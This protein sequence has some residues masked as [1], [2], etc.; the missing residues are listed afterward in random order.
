MCKQACKHLDHVFVNS[1]GP[2]ETPD[3]VSTVKLAA[4]GGHEAE[5]TRKV[6]YDGSS[7]LKQC[8]P[9]LEASMDQ[10]GVDLDVWLQAMLRAEILG[11][12]STATKEGTTFCIEALGSP[13]STICIAWPRRRAFPSL[14]PQDPKVQC[15]D[16]IRSRRNGTA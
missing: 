3:A 12:K 6:N 2:L 15:V 13:A 16:D 5:M 8:A 7:R 9:V 10:A 4:D 11:Q 14:R 1:E